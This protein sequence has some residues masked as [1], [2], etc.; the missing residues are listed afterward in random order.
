MVIYFLMVQVVNL[1]HSPMNRSFTVKHLDIKG[2]STYDFTYDM[3]VKYDDTYR[4]RSK[5]T[6][7]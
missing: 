7:V 2:S 6:A 3:G 5:K 4:N 1:D